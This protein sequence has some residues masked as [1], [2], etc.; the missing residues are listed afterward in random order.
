MMSYCIEA[1]IY[2]VFNGLPQHLAVGCTTLH[3]DSLD[4][5]TFSSTFRVVQC[6]LQSPA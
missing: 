1:W 3:W 6:F 5:R 2:L 4:S